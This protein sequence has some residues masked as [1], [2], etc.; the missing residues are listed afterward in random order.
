MIPYDWKKQYKKN[1][2]IDKIL[3][4]HGELKVKKKYHLI[5]TYNTEKKLLIE[6]IN[7]YNKEKVLIGDDKTNK[8][9]KYG[10][11]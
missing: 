1:M 8:G 2:S 5:Y 10:C 6:I 11:Y 7:S 9:E 4:K 3:Y